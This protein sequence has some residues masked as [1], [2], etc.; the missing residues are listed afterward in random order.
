MR[1]YEKGDEI[2]GERFYRD[3][4]DDYVGAFAYLLNEKA[5]ERKFVN[6]L[7]PLYLRESQAEREARKN[8]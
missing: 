6:S 2:P 5:A 1:Y 3:E 8:D 4:Q 7:V